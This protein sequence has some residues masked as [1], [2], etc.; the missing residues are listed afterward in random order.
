MNTLYNTQN[1]AKKLPQST[2]SIETI[3]PQ[4]ADRILTRN[5]WDRQRPERPGYVNSYAQTMKNGRWEPLSVIRFAVFEGSEYLVDG[6]HRLR[7]VSSSGTSHQFVVIRQHVSH[8]DEVARVYSSVD[9]GLSRTSF[10]MLHALG[11][12]DLFGWTQTQTNMIGSAILYIQSEFKRNAKGLK[13]SGQELAEKILEYSEAAQ[14]YVELYQVANTVISDGLRRRGTASVGLITLHQSR[15]EYGQKP[16]DFWDGVARDDS[17]KQGDPRKLA[18]EHIK[19]SKV[20]GGA[21]RKSAFSTHYSARY[22]AQ[23]FNAYI[24]DRQISKTYVRGEE[25][26]MKIKGTQFTGE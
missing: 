7:A 16:F 5:L 11:V 6:Q 10:D 13:L 22:I 8:H 23:C 12:D 15:K 25:S 2:T 3:T 26:P 4:I 1:A 24:E 20:A 19:I 18:V 21:S 9:R 17:L 14:Q